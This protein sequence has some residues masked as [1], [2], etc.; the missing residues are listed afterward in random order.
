M[1]RRGG[2]KERR[3]LTLTRIIPMLAQ[4]ELVLAEVEAVLPEV[5]HVLV[6]LPVGAAPPMLVKHWVHPKWNEMVRAG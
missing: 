3:G 1:G 4:V 6:A 2:E 5:E